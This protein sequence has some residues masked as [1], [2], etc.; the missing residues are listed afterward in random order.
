MSLADLRHGMRGTALSL[1]AGILLLGFLFQTEVVTA[2]QT[3]DDSTAYNHCFLVIPIVLYLLWDRRESLRG[4]AARPLPWIALAG[5]PLAVAWLLTERLG[6][7]EGRQLIALTFLELLFLGVLGWK[8]WSSVSGPLL[9]LYFLVP[10]GEFLTPK[11]QD[12]TAVFVR[13]GL[14]PGCDF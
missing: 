4:L 2:V 3:W 7:M 8:L 6:I 5:I 13:L 11:L 1:L 12:I 14:A 10:F 9:Y